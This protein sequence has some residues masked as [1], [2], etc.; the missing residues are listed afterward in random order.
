MLKKFKV[1]DDKLKSRVES[2]RVL[3]HVEEE[4][5]LKIIGI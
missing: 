2:D 3:I 5:L 4:I 1:I